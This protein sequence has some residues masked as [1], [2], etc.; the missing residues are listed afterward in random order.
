MLELETRLVKLEKYCTRLG[1]SHLD[2][3]RN[4]R[5]RIAPLCVRTQ[6]VLR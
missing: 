2:F 4:F 6:I 5:V 1:I 3:S